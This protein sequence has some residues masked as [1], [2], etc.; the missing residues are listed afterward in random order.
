MK[1]S[2]PGR[3][4]SIIIHTT[5]TTII[6]IIKEIKNKIRKWSTWTGSRACAALYSVSSRLLLLG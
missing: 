4:K 2:N 3:D 1:P 5:T 6:I